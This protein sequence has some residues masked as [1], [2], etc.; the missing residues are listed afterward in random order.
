MLWQN[1]DDNKHV[2]PEMIVR[3]GIEHFEAK[4]ELKVSLID[5][6]STEL[7]EELTPLFPM[8]EFGVDPKIYH[9]SIFH[10]YGSAVPVHPTDEEKNDS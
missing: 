1:R 10:M 2:T 4:Y 3:W 5:C 9:K 7:A 8:I 6:H